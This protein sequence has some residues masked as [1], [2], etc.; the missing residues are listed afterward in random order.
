MPSTI[1]AQSRVGKA[2]ETIYQVTGLGSARTKTKVG[3]KPYSRVL[4]YSVEPRVL[5]S[6]TSGKPVAMV[7]ESGPDI[8]LISSGPDI[9]AVYVTVRGI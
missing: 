1:V 7:Y 8:G 6:T 5:T 3:A 4:S 9:V 2:F